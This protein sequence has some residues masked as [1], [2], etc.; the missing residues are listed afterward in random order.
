ME[1]PRLYELEIAFAES[2]RLLEETTVPSDCWNT[3]AKTDYSVFAGSLA[4]AKALGSVQLERSCTYTR[5]HP[6]LA[7]DLARG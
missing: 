5:R 3:Q 1:I 7:K 2:E 6:E 4:N